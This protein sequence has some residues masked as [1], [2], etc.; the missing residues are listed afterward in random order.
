VI[1]DVQWLPGYCVLLVDRQGVSGLTDL[2]PDGRRQ[3]LD[4]VAILGEAMESA[5][6]AA[7]DDFRRLNLDL[8][9]SSRLSCGLAMTGA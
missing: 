1:G 4:S 7:D 5:C 2:D 3:Y 6:R 8:M 9:S